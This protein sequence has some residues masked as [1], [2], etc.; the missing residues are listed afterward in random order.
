[1]AAKVGQSEAQR[2]PVRLGQGMRALWVLRVD[3]PGVV[4]AR[5]FPV[6]EAGLRRTAVAT[7][8]AKLAV[9]APLPTSSAVLEAVVGE[10]LPST[11]ALGGDDGASDA[12]VAASAAGLWPLCLHRTGPLVVVVAPSVKPGAQHAGRLVDEPSVTVGHGL[13][14]TL[15]ELLA[16]YAPGYDLAHMGVIDVFVAFALPLGTVLTLDLPAI[17]K[18]MAHKPRDLIASVQGPAAV[19]KIP[20]SKPFLAKSRSRQVVDIR[21]SESVRAVQYDVPHLADVC[22]VQGSLQVKALLEGVPEVTVMAPTL[23][24]VESLALDPAVSVF[25]PT[26]GK[27]SLIPPLETLAVAQYSV[28]VSVPGSLPIRGFYQQSPLG[29]QTIHLLIQLKLCVKADV[30]Y[31]QVR[32]PFHNHGQITHVDLRPSAGIVNVTADRRALVWILTERWSVGNAEVEL[33]GTITFHGSP[34]LLD[35]DAAA[36]APQPPQPTPTSL[37][38]DELNAGSAVA[39]ASLA[40]DAAAADAA[41]TAVAHLAAPSDDPFCVASNAYIALDFK[42]TNTTLSGVHIARDAV[43]VYPKTRTKLN[44]DHELVSSDYIIWNSLGAS[45]H[46]VD[47]SDL[48]ATAPAPS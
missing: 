24:Q 19:A 27:L 17:R 2:T 14:A 40:A 31:C 45:R 18:Y 29:P 39:L 22:V 41:R 44:V 37:A 6:V 15:A 26:T 48:L 16:G 20:A 23:A 32:I 1:M 21:V 25:E 3:E 47:L 5:T 8:S 36:L 35:V 12:A 4:A 34:R 9:P 42:M 38:L 13:A 30:G 7:E 11:P 33:P 46:G 28:P 10:I 43:S